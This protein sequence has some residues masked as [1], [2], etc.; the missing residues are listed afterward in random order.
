VT[1]LGNAAVVAAGRVYSNRSMS[2][3]EDKLPVIN[4]YTGSEVSEPL[5][6]STST[7]KRTLTLVIEVVAKAANGETVDDSLDALLED[8]EDAMAD[9]L[10]LGGTAAGAELVATTFDQE[11]LAETNIGRGKLTYSTTYVY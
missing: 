4:V 2:I 7:Y 11:D 5:D 9:D 3:T 10:S 1:L 8:V 6:L